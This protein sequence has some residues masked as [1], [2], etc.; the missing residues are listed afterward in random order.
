MTPTLPATRTPG[1]RPAA[2]DHFQAVLDDRLADVTWQYEQ[3][4][5]HLGPAAR[6]WLREVLGAVLADVREDVV[7]LAREVT[8]ST[9]GP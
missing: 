4:W 8:R 5:E 9:H 6:D 7:T 1:E 3:R 2:V